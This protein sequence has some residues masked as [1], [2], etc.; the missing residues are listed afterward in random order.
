MKNWKI[1]KGM[2]RISPDL[3]SWWPVLFLPAGLLLFY[4]TSR[5]NEWVEKVYSRHIFKFIAQVLSHIAGVFPFSLG[6]ALV[7]FLMIFILCRIILF[8][9]KI[10]AQK[11]ERKAAVLTAIRRI[12]ITVSIIYFLFVFLWG[13]NYNR[14]TFAELSG[15][16]VK[17][18]SVDE[19]EE[20]CF[21]LAERCN[22]LR[23]TLDEDLNGV[24]KIDGGRRSA[25]ERAGKGY[26]EA[27]RDYPVL[28]GKYGRP[29][30]VVCSFAMSYTGTLGIYSVFTAEPNVNMDM[31]DCD[32]PSTICH[33]MAHQRGFAREDEANYIAYLTCSYHPDD[34]FKYSGALLALIYA[35]NALYEHAPEKYKQLRAEYSPGVV[36]DLRAIS[37]F[38]SE[39]EG[40]VE[41]ISS[42]INDTYLKANRQSDGVESYGR[43]VDLLLAEYRAGKMR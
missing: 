16:E 19:L 28:S 22:N 20:V 25:L 17:P 42:S 9:R 32:I 4:G 11:E 43:M 5:M 14:L 10:I 6:E 3:K 36:R 12:A 23:T 27:S 30:G 26:I 40:P 34:D 39:Y 41:D 8:F 35:G 33:E 13:L 2:I 31:A 37:D 29:K 24:M 15:L 38:W 1:N 21:I 7:I 18:S